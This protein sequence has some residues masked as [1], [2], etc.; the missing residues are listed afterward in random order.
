MRC[1]T[2]VPVFVPLNMSCIRYSVELQQLM[3]SNQ[4]IVKFQNI[5]YLRYYKIIHNLMSSRSLLNFHCLSH[6]SHWWVY[7]VI[8]IGYGKTLRTAKILS[9]TFWLELS[10]LLDFIVLNLQ[11]WRKFENIKTNF[12]LSTFVSVGHIRILSPF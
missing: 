2:I 11:K 1:N 9:I 5:S 7:A 8:I 10:L 3:P 6:W 4:T 12:D